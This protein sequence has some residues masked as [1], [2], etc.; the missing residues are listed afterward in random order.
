MT[1]EISD[2]V[3]MYLDELNV[4]YLMNVFKYIL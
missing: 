4:S 3:W 2:L 1:D